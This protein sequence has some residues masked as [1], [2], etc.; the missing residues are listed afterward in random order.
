MKRAFSA[1]FVALLPFF[2]A[3]LMHAGASLADECDPAECGQQPNWYRFSHWQGFDGSMICAWKRTWHG[4]NALATPLRSYYMPRVPS[5][6]CGHSDG[7]PGPVIYG[8][9]YVAYADGCDR[10]M[11]GCGY[12][13]SDSFAAPAGAYC[14]CQ[15]GSVSSAYPP[16]A[17][18][19]F[20][21]VQFER[22]GRIANELDIPA[23]PGT[24]ARTQGGSR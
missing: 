21:P 23:A 12:A 15:N 1:T 14:Q 18:V 11:D 6:C 3:L 16:E 5:Y 7:I 13:I 24:P 9:G 4:P 8:S 10:G 2:G 20:Q 22:L 17:A 19:G